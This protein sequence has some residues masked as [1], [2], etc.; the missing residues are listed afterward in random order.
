VIRADRED[1]T[2]Q[3]QAEWDARLT[4][5]EALTALV[6]AATVAR[7]GMGNTLKSRRMADLGPVHGAASALR[8][9]EEAWDL[10][11]LD[12]ETAA[13]GDA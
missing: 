8:R 2:A 10:A 12:L 3:V 13:G 9:A 1:L 6:D 11:R 7:R 4:V 5:S